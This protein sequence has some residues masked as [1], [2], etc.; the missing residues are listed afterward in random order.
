MP[1]GVP[2]FLVLEEPPQ[3]EIVIKPHASRNKARQERVRRRFARHTRVG[4][5]ARKKTPTNAT[6]ESDEFP[7][8]SI[9]A[10]AVVVRVRVLVA[11]APLTGVTVDGAKEQDASFG[12]APQENLTVPA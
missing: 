8:R 11:G 6:T 12:R 5:R 7:S 1:A 2:G 3:P 4:V 9:A 10:A